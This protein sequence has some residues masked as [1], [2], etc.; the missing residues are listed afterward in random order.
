VDLVRSLGGGAQSDVWLQMKADMLGIP[1][2][3]PR[4][5]EAASLGAAMLAATGAAQFESTAEA[6]EAWY[7]PGQRFE[8][9]SAMLEPYRE[10]YERYTKLYD[11]L[12]GGRCVRGEL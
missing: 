3:R 6:A 4:N 9:R 1:V 8:P 7:A 12:Y 5:A 2:E 10:V 11:R